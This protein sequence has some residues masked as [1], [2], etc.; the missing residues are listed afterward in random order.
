MFFAACV[1]VGLI[2]LAIAAVSFVLWYNK[3][4][5]R[6]WR[7]RDEHEQGVW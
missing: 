6:K 1:A 7:D 3:P 5:R 4:K 2:W